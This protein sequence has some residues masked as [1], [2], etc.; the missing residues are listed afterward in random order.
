MQGQSRDPPPLDAAHPTRPP[1][2]TPHRA[3]PPSAAE[4]DW[5]PAQ[6]RTGAAQLVSARAPG[7]GLAPRGAA[8][9]RMP[10]APPHGP[11]APSP[12]SPAARPAHPLPPI[13]SGPGRA[14]RSMW[15]AGDNATVSEYVDGAGAMHKIVAFKPQPGLTP[16]MALFYQSGAFPLNVTLKGKVRPRRPGR[17]RAGAG[18]R[19]E[20]PRQEGAGSTEG[21][22]GAHACGPATLALCARRRPRGGDSALMAP[23]APSSPLPPF[24]TPELLL[25][26]PVAPHRPHLLGE[27]VRPAR[28][29]GAATLRRQGVAALRQAH[30]VG[31]A[32]MK[33]EPLQTPAPS[34]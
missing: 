25:V 8:G 14:R 3:P 18:E 33:E 30:L 10:P 31:C 12:A 6:R 11:S 32:P 5:L 28:G 26:P 24:S 16:E 21:K 20:G 1:G 22:G 15:C 9:M 7:R 13:P 2:G 17:G 27:P 4:R 34:L 19:G 29:D 23:H